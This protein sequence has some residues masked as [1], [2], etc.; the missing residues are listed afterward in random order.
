M[1]FGVGRSLL[2]R[3]RSRRQP[4]LGIGVG[5][6]L[7]RFGWNPMLVVFRDVRRW[8]MLRRQDERGMSGVVKWWR[9]YQLGLSV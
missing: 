2:L 3:S 1:W 5:R 7:A 6:V 9:G 8:F 4:V